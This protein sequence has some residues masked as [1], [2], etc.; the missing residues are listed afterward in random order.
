V[1][2]ANTAAKSSISDGARERARYLVVYVLGLHRQFQ[3]V[4]NPAVPGRRYADC[5]M[6]ALEDL[7]RSRDECV[8]LSLW[9]RV[10]GEIQ[11]EGANPTPRSSSSW[12][13]PGPCWTS[14]W[15]R[16]SRG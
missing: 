11:G 10:A 9:V 7:A 4:E 2:A 6:D 13:S 16:P 3:G 14:C 1:L 15:P 8:G 5:V 12:R